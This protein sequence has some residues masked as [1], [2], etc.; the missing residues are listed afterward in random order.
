M[1][2]FPGIYQRV[3]LWFSKKKYIYWQLYLIVVLII[4]PDW[5][6]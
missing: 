2:V 6:L 5:F 3:L 4:E 1:T